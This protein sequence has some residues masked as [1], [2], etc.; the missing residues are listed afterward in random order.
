MHQKAFGGRSGQAGGVYNA[1]P[2]PLTGFRGRGPRDGK[3]M[4]A[5]KSQERGEKGGG[6]R[7]T[8]REGQLFAAD[9]TTDQ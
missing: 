6:E 1:P 7:G 3:E 9:I 5:D 4:E 2:G 8:G